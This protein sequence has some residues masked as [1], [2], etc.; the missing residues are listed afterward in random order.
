MIFLSCMKK[1]D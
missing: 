1:L